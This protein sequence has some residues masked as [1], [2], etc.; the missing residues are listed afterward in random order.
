MA[1]SRRRSAA[2]RDALAAGDAEYFPESGEIGRGA[3]RG[4]GAPFGYA[5][6]YR[7]SESGLIYLRACYYDPRTGQFVSRDPLASATRQP[8]G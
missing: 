8:F 5:A 6:L 3:T 7:D 4:R 1:T 2:S